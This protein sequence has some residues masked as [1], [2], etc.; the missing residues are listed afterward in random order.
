[1][2]NATPRHS[3]ETSSATKTSAMASVKRNAKRSEPSDDASDQDQVVDVKRAA[4]VKRNGKPTAD[5]ASDQE[6]KRAAAAKSRDAD[7]RKEPPAA[8]SAPAA[9]SSRTEPATKQPTKA[10]AQPSDQSPGPDNALVPLTREPQAKIEELLDA[11]PNNRANPLFDEHPAHY[12]R[13]MSLK[14][15]AQLVL[16]QFTDPATKSNLENGLNLQLRNG[17]RWEHLSA[18]CTA[19]H[20]MCHGAGELRKDATEDVRRKYTLSID[21]DASPEMIQA[22]PHLPLKQKAYDAAKRRFRDRMY[23]LIWEQD[24]LKD[25]PKQAMKDSMQ[26]MREAY[27]GSKFTEAEIDAKIDAQA[28]VS[29]SSTI[30]YWANA[31]DDTKKAPAAKGAAAKPVEK[32]RLKS[33]DATLEVVRY[34]FNSNVFRLKMGETRPA[35]GAA[36][37]QAKSLDD[38]QY[39]EEAETNRRERMFDETGSAQVVEESPEEMRAVVRRVV[40]K[41]GSP[42]K[43]TRVPITEVATNSDPRDRLPNPH[44]Y[45]VRVLHTGDLVR[46]L[47]DSWVWAI[48]TAAGFTER[49]S[50]VY[51]ERPGPGRRTGASLTAVTPSAAAA[52]VDIQAVVK[53]H[54]LATNTHVPDT[55]VGPPKRH[56]LDG[57]KQPGA[58]DKQAGSGDDRSDVDEEGEPRT[59]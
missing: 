25:G 27:A 49:I 19:A 23:R 34:R 2:P 10:A 4:S 30:K 54:A 31:T 26:S 13:S 9:K 28:F 21:T 8:K 38:V 14:T 18:P 33:Y 17:G 53:Q 39:D 51:L 3:F 1:M 35:R 57:T 36:P 50:G 41:P 44:D 55:E 7:K 5:D 45:T 22:D 47:S 24:G 16:V 12:V 58:D 52:P 32:K 6:A 46:V 29:Y 40:H 59:R 20:V 11:D 48:S 15:L 42:W 56:P 43:L 37:A